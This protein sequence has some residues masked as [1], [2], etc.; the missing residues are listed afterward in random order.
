MSIKV[1]G[2]DLGK[3]IFHLVAHDQF[4]N[5]EFRKK[6]SRQKLKE[7]LSNHSL[8]TI[9]FEACG[10]AHWLG[11]YCQQIG[12]HVKLIP[13]QYVRPYVK[14][15]KNDFIDADAIAE[16]SGRPSMRFVEV[17]SET[18]Q[19]IAAIHRIRSGY[20]KE[21]TACMSRVG[22]VLLEF[23]I[24]LPRGHATMKRLFGWLATQTQS[25]P[26]LLMDELL[27]V[28]E[29]YTALCKRIKAQDDKLLRL[30]AD[31]PNGRLL[32]SIPGVGDM[33]ASQC[34]ADLGSVKH[35]KNGRNLAAW[36]GL[37]PRQHSTGGKQT[38]LG[39]SKRGNKH[40]RTLFIHGARAILSKPD[41]TGAPF[42]DWLIRLRKEKSFNVACVALANKL[43][44]IAW[45]VLHH[46]QPF[47][48]AQLQSESA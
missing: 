5:I 15:N 28:H 23:G 47:N 41:K 19:V 35:F 27:S 40:L 31:H 6:L 45:A 21:R 42:G 9:A 18:A 24:S 2:I 22:A 36:L 10:G 34:L 3:S 29:Y 26:P 1:I 43:A 11:R 44:R 13:P 16:A 48:A 12:H 14:G 25:L 8:T 17:K 39:I 7:F 37:V 38:L 20:I 46:Q 33:T 4:G 32:K 30:V